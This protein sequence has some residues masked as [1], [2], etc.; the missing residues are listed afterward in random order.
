MTGLLP[1]TAPQF[2]RFHRKTERK[3]RRLRPD[4]IEPALVVQR[5]A[6]R[7]LSLPGGRVP[8]TLP[9]TR[10]GC[11]P[12]QLYGEGRGIVITDSGESA[13][14]NGHGVGAATGKGLGMKFAASVAF[15]APATGKLARLNNVLVL[16]E[17]VVKADGSARSTLHEWKV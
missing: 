11:I 13:I 9:R 15:Q 3:S 1:G 12:G 16:V 8:G 14:W 10:G 6:G 4:S 7:R 17:H 5:M 2:L